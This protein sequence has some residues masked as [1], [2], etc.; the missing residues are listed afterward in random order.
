MKGAFAS[1][2]GLA[3]LQALNQTAEAA[4][5]DAPEATQKVPRK[6]FGSTGV[7]IPIIQMGTCQTLDP[8]YDKRLH[9]CYQLGVDYIDTAQMY[10]EGQSHKTIAPFIKQVGDRKK[11]FV[12]TKVHLTKDEATAD[13]FKTQLDSCL[14]DL[15]VDYV[16]LFYMHM[17][18]HARLLEPEFIKMGE[19]LKKAGKIKF[20]GFST[21]HGTVPEMMNIG[22]KLGSGAIDAILFRYN[23]RQY[24]DMELNKAIDACKK[25]GIGLV[26]MKTL[27]SIPDDAEEAVPWLSKDFTLTQAK[28]KAVWADERIDSIA[29]QMS[30]VQQVAENTA[31]AMSPVKLSMADYMQLNRLAAHTAHEHCLGCEQHCETRIEG[32]LRVADTMRYLMYHD[33]YGE[34]AEARR[35]YAALC[36]GERDFDG[37]DLSAATV[38]CPQGIDIARRLERARQ[39]LS[40]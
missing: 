15:E 23:F 10:A 18:Q 16:D 25:A 40:A 38:A 21:H 12:A 20:F 27:G 1:G 8:V 22:A 9:R 28:L 4:P 29:S 13:K 31:A 34:K 7:D 35:R 3:I 5:G 39:M 26:A 32:G 30:S 36:A 14:A 17:T 6:P 33:C 37:V 19:D 11:L 24:G 2:T